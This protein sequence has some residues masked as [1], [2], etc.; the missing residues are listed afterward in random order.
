MLSHSAHNFSLTYDVQIEISAN[1]NTHTDTD[2]HTPLRRLHAGCV[3][4][5]MTWNSL[6]D[7]LRNL[8]LSTDSFDHVMCFHR[9]SLSGSDGYWDVLN[10]YT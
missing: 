4:G 3:A 10:T 9:A 1:L 5:P 6:T 2:T 7:S 8:L